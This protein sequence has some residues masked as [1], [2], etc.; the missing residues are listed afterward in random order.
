[1]THPLCGTPNRN[2]IQSISCFDWVFKALAC[3]KLIRIA[4][5][6]RSILFKIA[7]FILILDYNN[8]SVVRYCTTAYD[9]FFSFQVNVAKLRG[10]YH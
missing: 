1:M 6:F 4:V 9:I 10:L 7:I 2:L 3:F 8:F 5:T